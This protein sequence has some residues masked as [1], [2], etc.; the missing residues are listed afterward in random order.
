MSTIKPQL[1]AEQ[2]AA[3]AAIEQFLLDDAAD[4][5][6]LRGSAGTGKTSLIA[7]LVDRLAELKLAC[8]L[9]APT[10][11]AARILNSKMLPQAQAE[12]ETVSTNPANSVALPE[13][14]T[15][16]GAG[17]VHGRIYALK[18]LLVNEEAQ[19]ANDSGMRMIFPLVQSAPAV[20]LIIVDEASMLGDR[21]AL[22]DVM[23]FGSGRLLHDLVQFAR[24]QRPGWAAHRAAK[25]LFVGDAAQLPPVGEASSPALSAEYLHSN[26][27]LNVVSFDLQQVVRQAKDSAILER[28]TTLRNALQK[29]QFNQFSLPDN[30]QDIRQISQTEA[31]EHMLQTLAQHRSCVTV[32]HSNALALDYNRSIRARLWGAENQP[33]QKGDMLLVNRNALHYGLSNGDLVKV[34]QVA[35][36]AEI[37][38][39]RLRGEH[40]VELRFRHLTVAFRQAD[41]TITALPCM[42][43]ENLLDSPERELT[44]LEQRALLVHFRKRHPELNPKSTEFRQAIRD[45][46]YFN[47]VHV[48][49]GYAMTCHKAQGGEWQTV[50][51]DF[52]RGGGF[53]N[54]N[55]FRWA[56]TG[57][58][59]A[60]QQLLAV[61]PPC[62]NASSTM[63]WAQAAPHLAASTG[64]P[65]SRV[66]ASA[67]AGSVANTMSAPRPLPLADL[68]ADADWQRFAFNAA[69]APLMQVHCQLRSVWA[70]QDIQIV[71]LQH[72]QYCE[73][74]TLARDGRRATIQYY[75]NKHMQPGRC[76]TLPSATEDSALA[77]DA[78]DSLQALLS[79][80]TNAL[81]LA[82]SSAS[83][84]APVGAA[85]TTMATKAAATMPGFMQEFLQQL[86]QAM[87]NSNI[88]RCAHREMPYRLRVALSD[89]LRRGEIDFAYNGKQ[90]W[91][92]ACEVGK[93]GSSQGLFEEVQHLLMQPAMNHT[94][95]MNGFSHE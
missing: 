81:P 80:M 35:A 29:Q 36:Q 82:D 42:V 60:R 3:L 62:F 17:T 39:L 61:N 40:Q 71:Q 74:Y 48:K 95:P 8:S 88:R 7:H 32:V 64:T 67:M 30:G 43:L 33:I 52:Q 34:Q 1:N 14:A 87:Q 58:T 79:S 44:P 69:L 66:E 72:L 5:F 12:A 18:E 55:F 91:T 92:S 78:L 89:G 86:D 51:V 4:V 84:A 28:A 77:S 73:R 57:I 93:P 56:Y 22:Q 38:T 85:S 24:L 50:I 41:G 19:S 9:M 53:N 75:Y 94:Q 21:E 59:R 47:A 68:Q 6:I 90:L 45:D 10:G 76:N 83:C 63:R 15:I 25:L 31:L 23:R 16:V 2:Q 46:A 70:A 11:R 27:Q 20:N 65:G 13:A 54:P 37:V 49:Y 26:F